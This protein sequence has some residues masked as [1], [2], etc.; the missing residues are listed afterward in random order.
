[1]QVHIMSSTKGGVG[2]TLLSAAL[3]RV[4]NSQ[5]LPVLGV[6]LNE[7]NPDLYR[8]FMRK[9][10]VSEAD[11][12]E[13][14][15]VSEKLHVARP[16]LQDE[17]AVRQIPY[18]S[19][20]QKLL[21]KSDYA[22]WNIVVDTNASFRHVADSNF[23]STVLPKTS[24]EVKIFFWYIWSVGEIRYDEEKFSRTSST[25]PT[26]C[27]FFH[28]FNPAALMPQETSTAAHIQNLEIY[29]LL[30]HD[31][32]IFRDRSKSK[33][34]FMKDLIKAL[35]NS[36]YS[37]YRDR[38]LVDF[39]NEDPVDEIDTF[40]C[41]K[42]LMLWYTKDHTSRDL[43]ET[44]IQQYGGR[45]RNILPLTCY[46]PDLVGYIENGEAQSEDSSLSNQ[47]LEPIVNDIE[48]FLDTESEKKISTPPTSSALEIIPAIDIG[49]TETS[50]DS[51]K[52]L[53]CPSG[54]CDLL[55][56]VVFPKETCLNTDNRMFLYAYRPWMMEQVLE[57]I[58]RDLG[59][60]F[61]QFSQFHE[62]SN[63]SILQGAQI[64]VTLKSTDFQIEPFKATYVIQDALHRF[65]FK[66]QPLNVETMGPKF[67]EVIIKTQNR[68]IAKLRV[69]ALQSKT[70]SWQAIGKYLQQAPKI[71]ASYSH[72]DR[73]LVDKIE[74]IVNVTM[75]GVQYFRDV[76]S[77]RS[78]DNWRERVFQMIDEADYF[79][80]FW[81]SAAAKSEYV[82]EELQH[83][84]SLN[85]DKFIC[86]IYW[87]EPMPV[88]PPELANVHF[89]S[90]NALTL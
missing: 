33:I 88:P 9:D 61:S 53:L 85:R 50:C 83:A 66:L 22:K 90:L 76:T 49:I 8:L 74:R 48:K 86:P 68:I 4:L 16:S 67:G 89:S 57:S 64:T 5:S 75:E 14:S 69:S 18:V 56:T 13:I 12:W 47:T 43:Y 46:A 55:F 27:Q 2:K 70:A 81:S 60:D 32:S 79:Q 84:L 63:S 77:L 37:L 10:A 1:M 38:A 19:S 54:A 45:P 20:L 11:S 21:S 82:K 6:D 29:N 44:F 78:G 87:Q 71:F 35:G 39:F 40:E 36:T 25:L 41:A 7:I 24:H 59:S 58:S 65:D 28:V 34:S 15:E 23:L 80:L 26:E 31:L 30:S 73:L 3:I 42:R 72:E 51:A 17:L 62:I 52:S